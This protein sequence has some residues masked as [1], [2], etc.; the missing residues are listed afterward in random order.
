MVRMGDIKQE[1]ERLKA[2][3]VEIASKI[4]LAPDP[5]EKEELEQ[6]LERIERQI[7]ILEE[8]N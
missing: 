1:I 8:F 7:R 3:K 4:S 5:R 6:K 2:K